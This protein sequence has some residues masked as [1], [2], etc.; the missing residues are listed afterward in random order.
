M[1][2]FYVFQ[3]KFWAQKQ[4][5]KAALRSGDITM[6]ARIS[7]RSGFRICFANMPRFIPSDGYC[8]MCTKADVLII[9]V[10]FL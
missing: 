6:K 5:H 8:G 4:S 1:I 9:A 10:L 7:K 2:Y 3:N